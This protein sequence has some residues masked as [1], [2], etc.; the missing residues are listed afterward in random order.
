MRRPIKRGGASVLQSLQ[1]HYF[2]GRH[3]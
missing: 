3:A 1:A 2:G